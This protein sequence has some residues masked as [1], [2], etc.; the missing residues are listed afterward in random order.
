MLDEALC[1]V[2]ALPV[3]SCGVPSL[4]LAVILNLPSGHPPPTNTQGTDPSG[5]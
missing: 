4:L 1:G 2:V 5:V 3:P